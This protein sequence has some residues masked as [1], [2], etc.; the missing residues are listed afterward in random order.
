M[1]ILAFSAN[2][3]S[4]GFNESGKP[5]GEKQICYNIKEKILF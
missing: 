3:T 5:K 1:N 2:D 4:C